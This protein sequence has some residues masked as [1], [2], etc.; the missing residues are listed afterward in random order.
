MNDPFRSLFWQGKTCGQPQQ[1]LVK[2][3]VS[4]YV[5]RSCNTCTTLIHLQVSDGP[6]GV[7]GGDFAGVTAAAC[8]PSAVCL[9]ATFDQ[10]L[11]RSIGIALSEEAHTKGVKCVLAPTTC[12]HRHV[13]GGR[14][15]ES[16]SEDVSCIQA[17]KW[18]NASLM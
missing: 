2:F 4:R 18:S 12:M 5:H 8:F 1:F 15:F 9:A 11:V 16:F 17:L 6:N 10:K 7:R 13:L 14:N 3:P